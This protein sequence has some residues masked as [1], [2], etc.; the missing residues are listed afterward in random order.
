VALDESG[1][2]VGFA[3]YR[4]AEGAPDTWRFGVFVLP[5][6]RRRGVG[7]QAC[8]IVADSLR[9]RGARRLLAEVPS[10]QPTSIRFATRQG[11]AEIGGAIIYQRDAADADAAHAGEAEQIVGAQGLRLA[12]LDRFP[13]RGLA[14]RLLPIWNRT[15]PDQPQ[16]W[17]YAP[18]SARRLEQEMLEPAET[19]LRH[20]FAI[21][22]PAN[23]IVALA[24]SAQLADARLASIYL[25]VDPDFRGRRLAT[26]LKHTLI[27]QAHAHA[28]AALLAE[29]D[30]RNGA[31]RA[32][33]EGLGY[34]QMAEALVYQQCLA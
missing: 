21:I 24:L 14:E 20:S 31:M 27:A 5:A 19:A 15:R 8:Q 6:H 34:R 13:R 22:G 2:H 9:R 33:N 25:A 23:Q 10:S 32:I 29:N 1:D 18:Y 11:F 4:V 16:H 3:A 12:S 28:I 30:R 26:A 17:P 7:A